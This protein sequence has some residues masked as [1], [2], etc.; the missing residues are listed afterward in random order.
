MFI[1]SLLGPFQ[2]LFL[3][4]SICRFNIAVLNNLKFILLGF[5]L[6]YLKFFFRNCVS[7]TIKSNDVSA[8]IRA[9]SCDFSHLRFA[10]FWQICDFYLINF[11]VALWSIFNGLEEV[12]FFRWLL[13]VWFFID[14]F[15]DAFCHFTGLSLLAKN[16]HSVYFTPFFWAFNYF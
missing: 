11:L 12:L 14:A 7:F 15:L 13:A 10:R 4:L 6:I 16:F 2:E 3:F 1:E 5:L 8:L 9:F